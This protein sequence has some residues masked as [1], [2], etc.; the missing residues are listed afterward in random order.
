VLCQPSP[1]SHRVQFD[2]TMM[3]M[4]MATMNTRTRQA[5]SKALFQSMCGIRVRSLCAIV[6]PRDGGVQF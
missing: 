5:N 3:M 4:A 1:P 2:E 6:E